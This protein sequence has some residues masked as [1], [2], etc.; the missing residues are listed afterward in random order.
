M[1]NGP[2][3]PASLPARNSETLAASHGKVGIHVLK[4]VH[5]RWAFGPGE[6]LLPAFTYCCSFSVGS[7]SLHNLGILQVAL[8]EEGIF[9]LLDSESKHAH[10]S[11]FF[12][13]LLSSPKDTFHC[14]DAPPT[15]GWWMPKSPWEAGFKV[16]FKRVCPHF[17][18]V[19][20][21][22]H[23]Q[24]QRVCLHVS[25]LQ[26]VITAGKSKWVRYGY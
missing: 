15:H 11:C 2:A 20:V 19:N 4:K 23:P 3:E 18:I 16:P 10:C 21:H 9:S 6:G 12:L 24:I 22:L 1:D 5:F 14:K 17:C 26:K 7:S 13:H 8:G 25:P